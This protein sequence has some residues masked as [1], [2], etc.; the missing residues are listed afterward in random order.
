MAR[1]ITTAT[2]LTNERG[3]YASGAVWIGPSA[4]T[5]TTSYTDGI[6]T[7]PVSTLAAAK[8][9]ADALGM[10][11]FEVI[12]TGTIQVAAAL[13]GYRVNGVGWS[14]TTTG[15]AQ[16]VGTSAFIGGNI[17]AGTF[18]STSGTINWVDCEIGRASCR[19]RVSSPV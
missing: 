2:N 12:R 19:E 15:G 7:N 3:K 8:T 6:I 5:N 16:D 18:S 1:T 4:N 14:G 17:T 13:A 9:I 10:R 11:R